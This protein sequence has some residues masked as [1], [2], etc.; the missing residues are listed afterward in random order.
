MKFSG[1]TAL[2]AFIGAATAQT[3]QPLTVAGVQL[4]SYSTPAGTLGY[5]FP[6]SG[7]DF[8]AH[9]AGTGTGYVGFSVGGGMLKN[10]LVVAWPNGDKV[11]TGFRFASGY[12]RPSIY[13]GTASVQELAHT[14]DGT[15][16]SI[17]F[18]CVGCMSWNFAGT[19]GKL[20]TAGSSIRMGYA[21]SLVAPSTP[22]D[23]KSA[24]QF[25]TGGQG[26]LS[27]NSADVVIG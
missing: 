20:N 6:K 10:L 3:A 12:T 24:I 2:C 19:S 25:H 22:A 26:V 21:K 9:I 4:A 18:K 7:S 14:S 27:L 16:W 1:L 15:N 11:T 13:N 8:T 5:S 17:T 23:P